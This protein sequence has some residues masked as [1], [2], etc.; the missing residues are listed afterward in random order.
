M[1]LAIEYLE[2]ARSSLNHSGDRALELSD[3]FIEANLRQLVLRVRRFTSRRTQSEEISLAQQHLKEVAKSMLEKFPEA[4][5]VAAVTIAA[6]QPSD[7]RLLGFAAS[8]ADLKL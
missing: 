2:F 1:Q 7:P 3:E 5:Q 6:E 8:L 4:R